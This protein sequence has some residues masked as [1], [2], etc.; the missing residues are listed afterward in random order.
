MTKKSISN[1]LNEIKEKVFVLRMQK[2]TI[3]KEEF[4]DLTEKIYK[5]VCR[6]KD[7]IDETEKV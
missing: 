4:E 1:F 3:T 6:L 5:K 7:E 2:N